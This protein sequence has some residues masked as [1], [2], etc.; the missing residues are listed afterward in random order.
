MPR[1]P[2]LLSSI[3]LLRRVVM[4]Y[5]N[6][7]NPEA[8][9]CPAGAPEGSGTSMQALIQDL[10]DRGHS[11]ESATKIAYSLQKKLWIRKNNRRSR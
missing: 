2:P 1:P 5:E 7:R 3:C 9:F 8:G 10:V 4:E 6:A 11:E